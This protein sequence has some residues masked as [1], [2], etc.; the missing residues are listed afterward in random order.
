M[1]VNFSFLKTQVNIILKISFKESQVYREIKCYNMYTSLFNTNGIY[2]KYPWYVYF[3]LLETCVYLISG[4]Q[5]FRCK[6]YFESLGMLCGLDNNYKFSVILV[7]F[8]EHLRPYY[9]QLQPVTENNGIYY[10][11]RLLKD[12]NRRWLKEATI[13]KDPWFWRALKIYFTTYP[14]IHSSYVYIQHFYL[15]LF[16]F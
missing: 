11:K 4:F 12:F 6:L 14:A 16:R 8:N 2:K 1:S 7:V 10:S 9:D 5:N 15:D 3:L 13:T